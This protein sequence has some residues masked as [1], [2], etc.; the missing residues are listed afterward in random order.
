MVQRGGAEEP[1]NE[2]LS[3][4]LPKR[5]VRCHE[6]ISTVIRDI[7]EVG[8]TRVVQEGSVIGFEA[9]PGDLRRGNEDARFGAEGKVKERA[10]TL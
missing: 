1:S 7:G 9:F 5:S 2:K 8:F 4:E 6:N 10:M 3:H